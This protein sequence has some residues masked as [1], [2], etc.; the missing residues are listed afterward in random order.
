MLEKYFPYTANQEMIDKAVVTKISNKKY[1]G[2]TIDPAV[3]VTLNGKKLVEGIDYSVWYSNNIKCGTATI[4]IR[5]IR[6]YDGSITKTFKIVPTR[7]T[8]VKKDI[9]KSAKS[10]KLVWKQK[11]NA[12]KYYVYKLVKKKYKLINK[13]SKTWVKANKLKA[14]T[15]YS[16]KIISVI[17]S[18][19]KDYL[20]GERIVKIKTLRKGNK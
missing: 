17:N 15:K 20:G 13:T 2:Y 5:G 7:V 3:K 19:G 4:E 12:S 10:I 18:N 8:I 14:N 16:F 9:K 1:T 6:K 11:K